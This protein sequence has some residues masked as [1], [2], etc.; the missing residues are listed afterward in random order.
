MMLSEQQKKSVVALPGPERFKHFVKQV[1]DRHEAWGLYSDGW[2]LAEMREGS[3]VLPFWPAEDYAVLCAVDEWAGYVPERL[4]LADF[5][6]LLVR[7][8][9]DGVAPGVFY[10]PEDKGV[11]LPAAELRAAIEQELRQYE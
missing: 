8:E 3:K 6:D 5:M 1:A 2:A 7:L 9:A 4:D 10:T 11:T